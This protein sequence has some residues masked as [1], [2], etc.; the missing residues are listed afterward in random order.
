MDMDHI[1]ACAVSERSET[2]P[3]V[4]D[5]Q[6]SKRDLDTTTTWTADE[7]PDDHFGETDAQRHGKDEQERG[8]PPAGCKDPDP[9]YSRPAEPF[10]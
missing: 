7:G 6:R 2:K 9:T 10:G 3:N 5:G 4:R 8:E 1:R